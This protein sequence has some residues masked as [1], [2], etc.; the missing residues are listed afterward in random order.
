MQFEAA[1]ARA[2][3]GDER[4]PFGLGLLDTILAEHALA[5]GDDRL[6]RLGA[7][8]FGDRDQRDRRG[9]APGIAASR[10]DLLAHRGDALR[11]IH[12]FHPVNA[13][14]N[15]SNFSKTAKT[16]FTCVYCCTEPGSRV[17]DAGQSIKRAQA[18]VA[19]QA[20]FEHPRP[21]AR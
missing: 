4:R 11:S 17:R 3:T 21:L 2:V 14:S 8:G 15:D 16:T 19:Q 12:G 9:V 5:G 13:A 18:V 6:D 20:Y 10:R 1:L 7:E